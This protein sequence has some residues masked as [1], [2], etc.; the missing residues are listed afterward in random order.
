[1]DILLFEKQAFYKVFGAWESLREYCFITFM[2]LWAWESLRENS[3]ITLMN[4]WHFVKKIK[5][6]SCFLRIWYTFYLLRSKGKKKYQEICRKLKKNWFYRDLE[7]IPKELHSVIIENTFR[8]NILLVL[9]AWD[10]SLKSS[11]KDKIV[12][13]DFWLKMLFKCDL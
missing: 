2:P 1:M 3:F 13:L 11:F 4:L 6:K 12:V 9:R 10:C 7:F 8:C 5:L